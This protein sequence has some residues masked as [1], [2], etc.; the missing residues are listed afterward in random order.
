VLY[1][2]TA[3]EVANQCGVLYKALI[4]CRWY[5]KSSDIEDANEQLTEEA[6]RI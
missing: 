5:K 3:G 4:E 1:S 2:A 6:K